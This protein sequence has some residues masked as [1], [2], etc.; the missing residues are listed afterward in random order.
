M[1]AGGV[2]FLTLVAVPV[3]AIIIAVT[4]IGLPIALITFVLYLIACY[5]AKIIVAEFVGRSVMK[6]S[7]A[8]SLL[9]GLLMV[10]VA[11]NL[12]WI[13][14]LINFLLILLGLGVIALSVFRNVARRQAPAF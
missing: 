12:P 10:I 6:N 8:V 2:G 11:V 7:G 1:K 13:G 9:V 4:F 5:L 14:T 3:A